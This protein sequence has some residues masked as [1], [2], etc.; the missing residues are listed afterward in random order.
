V[1]VV[2]QQAPVSPRLLLLALMPLASLP[3][4]IWSWVHTLFWQQEVCW[5]CLYYRLAGERC[6][7]VMKHAWM[8]CSEPIC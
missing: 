2:E 1:A 6:G 8:L 4:V 5:A 3:M 7:V